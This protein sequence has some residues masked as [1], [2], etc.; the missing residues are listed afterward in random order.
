M[1]CHEIVLFPDSLVR[2]DLLEY[3][4]AIASVCNECKSRIP[5]LTN[6]VT[7]YLLPIIVRN[8]AASDNQ[9]RRRA[10]SS[11]ISLMELG[12]VS[13]HQAE[14]Q[15]CPTVIALST[16]SSLTEYYTGPVTVS[17]RTIKI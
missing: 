10:H 17:S 15:V 4:P 13:T 3:I 12:Y 6:I 1:C 16:M 7:E 14:V 8:I 2:N 11:L 5:S 9:V